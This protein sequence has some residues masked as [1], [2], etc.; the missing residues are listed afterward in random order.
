MN[1]DSVISCFDP[2]FNFPQISWDSTTIGFWYTELL[3]RDTQFRGW[4]F[5]G[6]PNCFWMTGFF[7]PQGFVTAMRQ[8][9]TRAHKGWALDTVVVHNDVTRMNKDD[10]TAPPTEGVYVYGLF[11]DGAGWDRK[12]CRLTESTPKVLFA[13]IPVVHIYAVNTKDA[14]D[15]K[16]YVCPVY[17]KPRRTDLTY[18]TA[19]LLKT[20][21]SPDHWIR[22][23]V[24]LLCDIK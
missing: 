1:R 4:V 10:V 16:L 12:N 19:L 3:E 7:N 13:P 5:D 23:G 17:K 24:A 21:Q 9:V 15:S 20:V 8:E 6:R 11:L 2:L 22:R 14:H 18:I